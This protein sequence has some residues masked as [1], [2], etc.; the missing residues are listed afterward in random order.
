MI[1]KRKIYNKILQWKRENNGKSAL[2]IE[3][4][5]RI[6]SDKTTIEESLK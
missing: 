4:A 2:L 3:G 5:R 1:F 6:L